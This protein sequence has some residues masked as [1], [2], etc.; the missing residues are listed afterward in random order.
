[1][2]DIAATVVTNYLTQRAKVLILTLFTYAA[3]C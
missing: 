3:L 2:I 1:M